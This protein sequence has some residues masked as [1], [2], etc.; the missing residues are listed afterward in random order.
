M[1]LTSCRECGKPV[2]GEAAT[3]PHCGIS[4]PANASKSKDAGPLGIAVALVFG[5]IVFSCTLK[6]ETTEPPAAKAA[7][8][9]SD[10]KPAARAS[11]KE[12]IERSGYRV[13]DWGQF[14]EW[15]VVQNGDGTWSVGARFM[16]AAPG[17]GVRNLYV[18]CVMGNSGDHWSLR[19][20]SKM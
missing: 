7:P 1:A 13:Q 8:E 20:L 10:L 12:F 3:C 15:T 11:C 18:T 6:Q 9:P 2:S 19:S 4:T 17:G 5:L 14:W 16:G